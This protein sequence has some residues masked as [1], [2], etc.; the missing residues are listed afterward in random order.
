LLDLAQRNEWV[1]ERWRDALQTWSEEK[2]ASRSWRCI[3]RI[4]SAAPGE[5]IKEIAQALSWWL[6]SLGKSFDSNEEA[7][8]VLVHRIVTLPRSEALQS[9]D[10]VVLRAIN[11]PVGLATEAAL[12]WWYRQ[13]PQDNQGLRDEIIPI[14]T[15][16]CD[17]DVATFRYGRVV[18]GTNL[19]ALFRVDRD[20]VEQYLLPLFDWDKSYGEARA[21]WM[22][23][24]GSPRLYR[25]LMDALKPDFL[26]TSE[27]H[28][29]L[30]DYARQY[31]GFLTFA[32][33]DPGDTFTMPELAKATGSLPAD[34]LA[35]VAQTLVQALESAG[36]QR[37]EYWRNRVVPYLRH[38]WPQSRE[39]LTPTIAT[40]FA[41]LCVAAGDQFPEAFSEL[42]HWLR[43][44]V[45]PDFV[46]HQVHE[47]K[48]GER[49]PSDTLKFL[50]III[51][52]NA[53]LVSNELSGCLDAIAEARPTLVEDDDFR[54][55]VQFSR[56]HNGM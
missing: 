12:R 8:F 51:S 10:D 55:L 5:F 53:Q 16:I 35:Q 25:P 34:G 26:A 39:S 24:L 36:D 37:G 4:L 11:H 13:R 44:P 20:W 1:A 49:F 46:V 48:L 7:F 27:Y 54:R 45:H 22:G 6:H 50:S 17:P 15:E 41:R 42:R 2:L 29:D 23:F 31:A 32:A 40:N 47:T 14:L 3:S 21:V 18:L 43:A 33:L 52:D 9:D 38:V 30:G 19:I 56:R 28:H